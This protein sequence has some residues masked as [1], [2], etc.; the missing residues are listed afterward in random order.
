MNEYSLSSAVGILATV[1]VLL[2][3]F[4]VVRV[5]QSTREFREWGT[6]EFTITSVAFSV[7]IFLLWVILSAGLEWLTGGAYR[8]SGYLKALLI[9]ASPAELVSSQTVASV[10]LYAGS[11]LAVTLFLY[12]YQF[13]GISYRILRALRLNRFSEHLTPWEDFLTL[14]RLNWI[15]V[16]MKDGRTVLGKVG[17]FSHMPF[18]R[19][20]VLT[21]TRSS[22]V[23]IYDASHKLI[24]FGPEIA[25]S[26]VPFENIQAMHAIED[27]R[28][29]GKTLSPMDY[30]F[31]I[32]TVFFAILW[33]VFFTC[34][35]AI[36][37]SG[38]YAQSL[39]VDILEILQV[40]SLL[41]LSLTSL[42]R[43]T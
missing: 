22:P 21:R 11:F 40:G 9:G 8:F 35:M 43:H 39:S 5:Q 10:I 3:G 19:Q 6:F 13:M 32:E 41:A 30:L 36:A 31:S 7:V 1:F 42:R 2:P 27:K 18:E 14:N 24:K 15:A 23:A 17:L 4:I 26:Y 37:V 38:T 25:N 12:S 20:L 33:L 29:V 28:I 16:E 34:V